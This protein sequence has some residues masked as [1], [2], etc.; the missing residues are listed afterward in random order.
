MAKVFSVAVLCFLL[1]TGL[2]FGQNLSGKYTLSSQGTTLTLTLNQDAKGKIKGT[3][4]ST[5]GMQFRVEGVMQ[6]DVG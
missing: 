6:D 2:A 3:L 4:S 1:I 5:S